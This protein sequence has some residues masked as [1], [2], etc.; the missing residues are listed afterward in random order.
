MRFVASDDILF[1]GLE[2]VLLAPGGN[3]QMSILLGIDWK[4]PSMAMPLP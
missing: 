4:K 1:S 3:I 2:I